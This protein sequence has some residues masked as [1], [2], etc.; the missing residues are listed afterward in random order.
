MP[1]QKLNQLQEYKKMFDEGLIT[2]EE[3]VTL[4]TEVL[5][6]TDNPSVSRNP[7]HIVN[8]VQKETQISDKNP[9]ENDSNI[10]KILGFMSAGL[11]LFFIPILFGTLG[12]IFGIITKNREKNSS[13]GSIIIALSIGSALLGSILGAIVGANIY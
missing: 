8:D 7:M 3:F 10:F 5:Q 13:I 9:S 4:K 11:A 2:K 6:N 1:E 12:A